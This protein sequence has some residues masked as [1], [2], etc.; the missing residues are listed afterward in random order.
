M[1]LAILG[2]MGSGKST[3]AKY[4]KENYNFKIH[5]FGYPVKKFAKEIFNEKSKNRKLIQDFAQKVKEIDPDVWV[6]YLINNL[7]LEKN[8]VIDDLRFP[9]EYKVLKKN[10][11]KI[12]KLSITDEFQEI[13]L[14]NTYPD[15]Y[16]VH[17]ERKNDISES[18]T[19]EILYDYLFKVESNN[20]KDLH[21]F[22]DNIVNNNL[23]IK[24]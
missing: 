5:S 8:I 2:K 17:I 13:R 24:D 7:D 21:L 6:K 18:Y 15:N 20:I 4:L 11:F 14:K 10:G 23:N 16:Q 12:I 19:D 22:L 3:S 9:N 1:K